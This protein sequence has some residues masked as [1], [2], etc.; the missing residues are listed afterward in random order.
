MKQSSI[1]DSGD[2]NRQNQNKHNQIEPEI[3]VAPPGGADVQRISDMVTVQGHDRL[4]VVW[5]LEKKVR[6]VEIEQEERLRGMG[7]MK[8]TKVRWDEE[9]PNNGYAEKGLRNNAA[10]FMCEK[11][12]IQRCDIHTDRQPGSRNM[13]KTAWKTTEKLRLVEIDHEEREK[14]RGFMQR[15]KEKWDKE[16]PEKKCAAGTLIDNARRFKEMTEIKTLM[17]VK[18]RNMKEV[19]NLNQNGVGG[20]DDGCHGDGSYGDGIEEDGGNDVVDVG[21]AN[22][23][24]VEGIS[25]TED[26]E[27]LELFECELEVVKGMGVLDIQQREALP[28]MKI[29]ENI[30]QSANRILGLYLRNEET[31]DGVVDAVY[32]MGRAI[33]RLSGVK[34][35]K[36]TNKEG[37]GKAAGGNRRERKRREKMKRLRQLIAKAGNEIHRKRMR[38]KATRKEKKNLE[39]LKQESCRI[40]GNVDDLVSLKELWLEDLRYQKV[41]LK[42]LQTKEKR[43]RNNGKFMKDEG[44]F[45]KD[46]DKSDTTTGKAP[47]I[48]EFVEFWAGIWEGQEGTEVRPWMVEIEKQISSRVWETE[49]FQI[50]KE[51]LKKVIKKRKNWTAPGIDGIQNYWWKKLEGSWDCLVR[52]MNSWTKDPTSFSGWLMIGRTVLL[53]KTIDL[54]DVQN[55]RPITCLNTIYKIYTGIIAEYLKKHAMTNNLWDESQMG[56]REKVLGTVDQLLIDGCIMEEVKEHSRNVVVAYYDYKKAYDMVHHDWI[57]MVF[58]WMGVPEQLCKVIKELMSGWKTRLEV[59]VDGVKIRSRII[60]ILRGFLQG[61]SFSPVGYCLVNVPIGM[62]IRS[63]EGYLMGP[64]GDRRIKK[65]HNLFVDDLKVYQK[66]HEKMVAV[67]N[68]IVQASAD[69]GAMYGV[70]KCAEMVFEHGEMV[71]GEGLEVL[72]ERMEALDPEKDE[73]YKFLGVE[74]GRGVCKELVQQRVVKEMESRLRRLVDMEL[75]DKNLMRAINCRVMPI[76]G[77][78]MNVVKFSKQDLTEFDMIVKRVLREKNMLGRQSSDERIYLSRKDGGR[79]LRCCADM[80]YET[81]IRVACYMKLSQSPWMKEVWRREEEKEFWSVKKEAENALKQVGQELVLSERQVKLNEE[82]LDGDWKE[83]YDK[84]KKCFKTETRKKRIETYNGKEMQSEVWRGQDAVCHTWMERNMDP[85]KTSAIVALQEQMVETKGWKVSRGMLEDGRC[86]LCG[87]HLETVHHLVSGC[88]MLAGTEYLKRHNDMLK[89][90]VV[91]WCK[92]EGL[93]GSEAVWYEVKWVSGTV[94]ESENRKMRWDFQCKLRKTEKHRRPDVEIEMKDEKKIWIVDGACPMERNVEIKYNEKVTNYSQLAFETRE[95]R[96]CYK[97]KILPIIIGSLGKVNEKS[98]T[99]MK[100]LIDGER[101]FN[102]MVAEME[103]TVLMQ[104][105]TIVR[106]V[107]SGLMNT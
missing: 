16:F 28:K 107:L 103:K 92:Q 27:L 21:G 15:V 68:A 9:Y 75:Y 79:G 62:L 63:S 20:G 45:Y 106:K 55:Y 23:D 97:V 8:R 100:K 47:N 2:T 101:T 74:Q 46:M 38:R 72:E 13:K 85:A 14:G 70:K 35:A 17:L 18:K 98:L 56:A 76:V 91:E 1:M 30:C 93:M 105:E 66:N 104:S 83:V 73:F 43:R 42:T 65:T 90:F 50:D 71:K 102:T 57:M 4:G 80:Y 61:D 88:K 64:P 87:E 59:W 26:R 53:S 77:Y 82:V 39:E 49:A 51:R 41:C 52:V 31:L 6:L 84:V 22:K 86:R 69:T 60:D 25:F 37:K 7:F 33:C 54:S 44:Q 95:K 3:P 10:Q 24:E 29:K 58:K 32:A 81:K 67:N 19:M 48:E 99:E 78:A 89:F 96:N 5:T 94:L 40:N 11:E 34:L 36:Q 12:V